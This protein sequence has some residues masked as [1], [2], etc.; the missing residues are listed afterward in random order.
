MTYYTGRDGA[1]RLDGVTIAKVTE[2]SIS[3]SVDAL[4]T[5]PL[6]HSN[7][8][9]IAG[10]TDADGSATILYY[11]EGTVSAPE[12]LVNKV[13][14]TGNAPSAPVTLTLIYGNRQ[15]KFACIITQVAISCRTGDVMEARINYKV[16]DGFTVAM[17]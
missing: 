6:G 11:I 4:R 17:V 15:I 2:W 13:I 9:Y 8:S 5:T 10:N 3:A 16:T 12:A 7:E 14:N 1:L